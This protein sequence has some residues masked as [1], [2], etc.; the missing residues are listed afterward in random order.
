MQWSILIV[1]LVASELASGWGKAPSTAPFWEI[2][3]WPMVATHN[4]MFSIVNNGDY[5]H[6]IDGSDPE[7]VAMANRLVDAWVGCFI[8]P[9]YGTPDG[10]GSFVHDYPASLRSGLYKL[11]YIP[12]FMAAEK[13]LI[14]TAHSALTTIGLNH[15]A[16]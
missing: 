11:K 9:I 4:M 14:G 3:V 16:L 5:Q 12:E 15:S 1:A 7:N 10:Q 6:P 2:V 13:E 8:H